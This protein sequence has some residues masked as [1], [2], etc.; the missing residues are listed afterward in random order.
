MKEFSA[1]LLPDGK[2][3][4]LHHGPIDLV[5]FADTEPERDRE[6]AFRAAAVRFDGLLE[7]IVAELPLLRKPIRDGGPVPEGAI[8]R[9]MWDAAKP[10]AAGQF[11]TPM[12]AVAG[13]VADTV[14]E[15]M[16][17][18]ADIARA[19]VNNG[20]DISIFLREGR[21]YEAA[22]SAPSG[23]ELARVLIQG[24]IG[25]GGMA[26]SGMGG[27]SLSA[28]IADAATVFAANAAAADAAATMVANAVD[29]PGHPSISRRRA[30]EI[31]PETDLIGMDVA[32]GCGEL[33]KE[34][35]ALALKRGAS[36][37]NGMIDAGLISSAALFLRGESRM[38]GVLSGSEGIEIQQLDHA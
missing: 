1:A 5:I 37:A 4:H 25:V 20:G 9:R 17:R 18:A 6:D 30:E 10:H 23:D 35:A 14:M 13:A 22:I 31:N 27:R 7:E 33:S 2:R 38:L 3:L 34:D 8:A 16:L 36:A 29:I 28:G 26:T 21:S 19:Y 32:T 24:G 15:A 12:A 11:I